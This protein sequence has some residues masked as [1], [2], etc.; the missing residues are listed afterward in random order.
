LNLTSVVIGYTIE[1]VVLVAIGGAMNAAGVREFPAWMSEDALI[2]VAGL[3]VA[4]HAIGMTV[5]IIGK[6]VPSPRLPNLAQTASRMAFPEP[7][8]HR[9]RRT[10]YS[11][12][13][14]KAVRP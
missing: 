9:A 7:P 6:P 1:S 8:T 12:R 14:R 11:A 13:Q 2:I 5:A 10:A 4:A 3:Y